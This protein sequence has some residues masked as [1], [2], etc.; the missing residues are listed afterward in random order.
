[1]PEIIFNVVSVALGDPGIAVI[2]CEG[3][4]AKQDSLEIVTAN[5]AFASCIS[6]DNKFSYLYGEAPPKAEPDETENRGRQTNQFPGLMA[7][8]DEA[9]RQRDEAEQRNDVLSIALTTKTAQA[10]DLLKRL[11][12]AMR[13][14]I[15]T[16]RLFS[17]V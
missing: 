3:K 9:I 14:K 17:P 8:L 13:W 2:L 1:M 10:E 6:L 15:L 16:F 11:D 5:M 12:N 4:N 7:R